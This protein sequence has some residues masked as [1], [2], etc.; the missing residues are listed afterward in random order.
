M[1]LYNFGLQLRAVHLKSRHF[2]GIITADGT[3]RYLAENV[4]YACYGCLVVFFY[5]QFIKKQYSKS[6]LDTTYGF[7]SITNVDFA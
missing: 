1:M 2:P 7:V 5:N 6:V 3:M 4:L